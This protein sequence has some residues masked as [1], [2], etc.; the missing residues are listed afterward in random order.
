MPFASFEKLGFEEHYREGMTKERFLAAYVDAR[1][2]KE[3]EII[4]D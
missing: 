4:Q 1:R 2:R 3:L